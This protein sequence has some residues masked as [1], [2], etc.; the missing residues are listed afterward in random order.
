MGAKAEA[1]EM[2]WVK[3]EAGARMMVVKVGMKAAMNAEA[4]AE[5]RVGAMT[6]VKAA[7]VA[8]TKVKAVCRI[9]RKSYCPEG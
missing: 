6:G 9:C 1:G 4:M 5:A 8:G 2:V 3:E 7:A